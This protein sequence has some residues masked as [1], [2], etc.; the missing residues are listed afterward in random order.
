MIEAV[1]KRPR[2]PVIDIARGV[3]IV[4]MVIYHL[5]WDLSFYG[6]IPVDVGYDPGWVFFARSILFAFMFLVGIGLV[7]GHGDG[8]R[9]RR[10]WR[11]WLFLVAGALLISLGTWLTFPESFVYFGVLHAIALFSLLA[12]PFLFT[13]IWLTAL[14]GAVVIALHFL[15]RDPLF[16]AVPLSWIGFWEVP[17]LTND[18]VPVFPW[19]GVVLGGIVVARLVRGSRVE[20]RLGEIRPGNRLARTLGWMGRWSLVIYVVHQPLLLAVIAPLSMATGAQDAGREIEFLNSCQ[21]TCEATGT[22]AALCA[23]YCQCGLDG[24]IRD[25]LWGP[26][27]SG[28][29]SPEEQ[30]QLDA[31]NRQCSAL[32][33]PELGAE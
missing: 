11:R 22:S 4:A 17:P 26:I 3:A 20:T 24:V 23:T 27:Y 1:E 12:L 21:V 8:M 15:Y 25:E 13:P 10:F 2:L 14:V 19:L 6:F 32:I 29:V 28:V 33:Y 7:L 16:N 30:A 9:W 31:N 5:C 18:L